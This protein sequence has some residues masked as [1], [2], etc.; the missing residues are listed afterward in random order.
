MTIT[1]LLSFG[2][3]LLAILAIAHFTNRGQASHESFFIAQRSAPW[4]VVSIGMIG[5]TISGVSFVS[6]PGMLKTSSMTYLQLCIGF[7]LG[8]IAVAY[9]LLPLYYRLQVIS[10]YEYL[11]IR[12]GRITY[13]TGA[14]FFLISKLFG[15]AAKLYLISLILQSLAFDNLGIPYPITVLGL[16]AIIWFYTRKGGMGTIIWTDILQTI[17]LVVA[18]CLI[19]WEV[20]HVLDLNLSGVWTLIQSSPYNK[21][22][23]WRDWHSSQFFWKQLLSGAL[24]VVVMTGLDQNMMQKNLTCRSL[25]E[26]QKNMLVYGFSFIPLN[27]LFLV[28]GL[29]LLAYAGSKGILLPQRAD[30]IL[31]VLASNYLG[32]A[33]LICFTI[34]IT[35]SSFSNADS[36]LTSL[37]TSACIDILGI[38]PQDQT[39]ASLRTRVHAMICLVFALLILFIA[40][41][42]QSSVID[43]IYMAVSYTYGPLLGL[44]A[45]GLISKQQ[46][47]D[48][49]VPYVCLLSPIL[50]HLL[51]L[52]LASIGYVTSY[53]L[54][55]FN[56][57]ITMLGLWLI[58][59]N[60]SYMSNSINN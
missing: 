49:Y 14:V 9:I 40:Q 43:T 52:G 7:F 22:F 32:Q 38:K 4:W 54:L 8:Y 33:T 17:S 50:S 10:I 15:S 20:S 35:A 16:V 44:Y 27:Y 45:F 3:Y 31:P 2:L 21:V 11:A 29:L 12:F 25:K 60:K 39:G 34:G 19:V 18:L 48:R 24:I 5:D 57:L 36:A 1:I 6:V 28:L 26:S 42:R 55:L 23:E 41:M 13:R 46:I 51:K 30:M 47:Y 56:G 59:Q 58:R 53:E 37:T